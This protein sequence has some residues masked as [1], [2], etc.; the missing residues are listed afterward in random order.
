LTRKFALLSLKVSG[1]RLGVKGFFDLLRI[2][3]SL[4]PS[5]G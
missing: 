1:W 4:N 3:K 2:G 5:S